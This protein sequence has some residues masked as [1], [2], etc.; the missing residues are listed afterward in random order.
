MEEKVLVAGFLHAG[1]LGAVA[2]CQLQLVGGDTRGP[3]MVGI[4]GS[5]FRRAASK[6]NDFRGF[7]T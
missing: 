3:T 5:R 6:I 2:A 7:L 1:G 4:V